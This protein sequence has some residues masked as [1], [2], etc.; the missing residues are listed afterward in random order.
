MFKKALNEPFFCKLYATLCL[1]LMQLDGAD[2]SSSPLSA[3]LLE[4]CNKEFERLTSGERVEADVA[5]LSEADAEIARHTVKRHLIGY[6]SFVAELFNMSIVPRE[7]FTH[8]LDTLLERCKS[9]VC[10]CFLTK[11]KMVKK[12]SCS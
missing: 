3:Y 1:S 8:S 6:M 10:I 12:I 5:G 7:T 4:L 11:K 2:P 9:T